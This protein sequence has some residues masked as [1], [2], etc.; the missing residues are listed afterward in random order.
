MSVRRRET[1][2]HSCGGNRHASTGANTLHRQPGGRYAATAAA[3]YAVCLALLVGGIL[4]ACFVLGGSLKN[5]FSQAVA[6]VHEP[7]ASSVEIAGEAARA[8][9]CAPWIAPQPTA[10]AGFWLAL[11]GASVAPTS[12]AVWMVRRRAIRLALGDSADPLHVPKDLQAKFV[13][14]RQA[15]L[16]LLFADTKQ[17][18]NGHLVVRNIMSR[19]PMTKSPQDD[20]DELR[21]LMK[22]SVIRHLLVCSPNGALVGIVSDRDIHAHGKM[23]GRH[24]DGQSADGPPDTPVAP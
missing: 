13:A 23:R 3:E 22:E 17:L 10:T 11:A 16:Q 21:T 15:M 5:T 8:Q 14:K 6:L 12:V 18:V 4:A 19:C 2:R 9:P 24:H 1:A 20:V 7:H